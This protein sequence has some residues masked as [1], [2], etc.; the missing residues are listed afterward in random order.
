MPR[1]IR[2]TFFRGTVTSFLPSPDRPSC[3]NV[4]TSPPGSRAGTHTSPRTPHTLPPDCHV[5]SSRATTRPVKWI[6]GGI[7]RAPKAANS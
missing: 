2:E 7:T 6:L 4:D 5:T 3:Y 1:L